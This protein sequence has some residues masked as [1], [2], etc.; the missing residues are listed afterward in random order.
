[1]KTTT[2]IL[3]DHLLDVPL[4]QYVGAKRAAGESWRN[5]AL[6]LRDDTDGQVNVTHET[7][8]RWFPGE[9]P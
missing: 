1:M 5:I 7:L 4:A 2:H 8:R 3:A 6:G 9:A